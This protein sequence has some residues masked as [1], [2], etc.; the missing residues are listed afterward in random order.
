MACYDV[1]LT[2]YRSLLTP[3]TSVSE[4]DTIFP[5]IAPEL[6]C[7]LIQEA[8]DVLRSQPTLLHIPAP[9][10]IVGDIHGNI[11]D[12]LR[13]LQRFSH[14]TS[15]SILFLGDYVD[16]GFHSLEVITLLFALLCKYPRNVFLIRGNHEF[17]HVNRM[18]GFYDEVMLIYK[19][20][21]IWQEFQLAFSWM[22][23]AAVVS[24][25]VFCVHGGLSPELGALDQI[26]E[27]KRPIHSY[28]VDA[29][30]SDLVWSDPDDNVSMFTDNQRGSGVLFGTDATRQ[31][32][33]GSKLKLL[34]R[35]HQCVAEGFATF[36]QNAG[37][38][39]FS[40][41]EYCSLLH[42]KCGVVY[43]HDN[44]R[45]DIYSFKADFGSTSPVVTMTIG[46][47]IGM[48]HVSAPSRQPSRPGTAKKET[49]ATRSRAASQKPPPQ[50]TTRQRAYSSSPRNVAA[51]VRQAPPPSTV[52]RKIPITIS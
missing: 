4:I 20:E 29:M 15:E 43:I 30:V 45:V 19:N 21:D 16:R 32:L 34:I 28:D 11:C 2:Q 26:G 47:E 44:G 37:V 12:L 50:R 38:T 42:N 9:V 22:P 33:K 8:G 40:S 52:F 23:L 24:N 27:V 25:R 36:G 17:S 5:H 51:P 1:V 13:I 49:R 14:Y 41:S 39:V 3:G 18:Y 35:A 6:L 10:T 48:Q 7:Q 46:K 31:F